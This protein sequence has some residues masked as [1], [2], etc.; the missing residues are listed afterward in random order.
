MKK[1]KGLRRLE[2]FFL[3]T[4]MDPGEEIT[5]ATFYLGPL[6]VQCPTWIADHFPQATP[7]IA[8]AAVHHDVA[9]LS[10]LRRS[11]AAISRG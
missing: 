7:M 4:D 9:T 10:S 6:I 3:A 11:P 2:T 1:W 5:A 8:K